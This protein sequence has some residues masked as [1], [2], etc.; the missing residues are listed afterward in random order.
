MLWKDS[1]AQLFICFYRARSPI[2][3]SK[4]AAV[5]DKKV[6]RTQRIQSQQVSQYFTRNQTS[7]Q[8]QAFNA[9]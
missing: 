6:G 8:L 4:T 3:R 2:P 5:N 1:L 9:V 7:S